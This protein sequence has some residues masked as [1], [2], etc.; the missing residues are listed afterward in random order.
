MVAQLNF[1]FE[2]LLKAVE[3]DTAEV[4]PPKKR[5]RYAVPTYIKFYSL[6]Q[7]DRLLFTKLMKEWL[8]TPEGINRT[9]QDLINKQNEILEKCYKRDK[10]GKKLKD[11]DEPHIY[12]IQTLHKIYSQLYGYMR[13]LHKGEAEIIMYYDEEEAKLNINDLKMP[14]KKRVIIHLRLLWLLK[15]GYSIKDSLLILAEK[16]KYQQLYYENRAKINERLRNGK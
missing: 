3:K 7:Y 9:Y 6:Y 10:D 13:F 16:G 1:N 12:R 15:K 8:Q 5:I 14:I 4:K 2:S 11:S